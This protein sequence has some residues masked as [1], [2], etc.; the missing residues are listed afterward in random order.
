MN[1]DVAV[2]NEYPIDFAKVKETAIKLGLNEKFV[3]LLF[4]R[5]VSD[6]DKI[7][8]FLYPDESMF[9]DPFLLKAWMRL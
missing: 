1:V 6:E 8:R 2:K 7:K 3:E 9:Y 5:G 4:R